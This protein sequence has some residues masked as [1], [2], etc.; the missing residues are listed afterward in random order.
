MCRLLGNLEGHVNMP[1]KVSKKL[2]Q[3]VQLRV[4]DRFER[5]FLGHPGVA[6]DR[7][8][9]MLRNILFEHKPHFIFLAEP[10]TIFFS[11]KHALFFQILNYLL[12]VSSNNSNSVSRLWCLVRNDLV[13]NVINSIVQ[14]IYILLCRG[15]F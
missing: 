8:L 11:D 1:L 5:F 13:F 14:Y 10:M 9:N 15:K 12:C 6:N 2:L 7:S 3:R 4:N